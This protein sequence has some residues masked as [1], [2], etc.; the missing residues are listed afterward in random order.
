MKINPLIRLLAVL[1][2]CVAPHMLCA[3]DTVCAQV[4]IR[5]LQK[6]TMERQGFEATLQVANGL[7]ETALANFTVSLLFSDTNGNLISSGTDPNASGLTFWYRAQ[8]GSPVVVNATIAGGATQTFKWLIVP[9]AGAAQSSTGG[10]IY[11]VGANISYSV[12]GVTQTT[13]VAPDYVQVYPTPILDLE[14]FLPEQVIGQDPNTPNMFLP[15]VPFSLGVRIRNSGLGTAKALNISSGQPQIVR[16]DT[17]L[18]ISFQIMG[19]EVQGLPSIP[20][21]LVNFGDV[22]GG[23]V[24]VGRWIMEA[25][26]TGKFTGFTAGFDHTDALGG[27]ATSL[28]RSATTYR[29]LGEVIQSDSDAIPDFLGY[30]QGDPGHLF[31]FPSDSSDKIAVADVSASVSP[32]GNGGILSLGGMLPAGLIFARS[33]QSSIK[34]LVVTSVTRSD[35]STLQARNAWVS[36]AQDIDGSFRWHYYLNIF[37]SI[38]YPGSYSYTIQLGAPQEG[39]HSPV[40]Q[41]IPDHYLKVDGSP[42]AYS[43]LVR[44]SDQDGDAVSLGSGALPAGATFNPNYTG[45]GIASGP[46]L[47]TGLFSWTPTANDAGEYTVRFTASDGQVATARTMGLH[48]ISGTASLVDAWRDKNWPGVSDPGIIGNEA[49]PAGDGYPNLMKYALGADPTKAEG[50]LTTIG[51]VTVGGMTYL[52]LTYVVR[53]DDPTLT[54]AVQAGNSLMAGGIWTDLD[55]IACGISVDQSDVPDGFQ[56][57]TVRDSQPVSD[58]AASRRYLR[59]KV[60]EVHGP[61]GGYCR[62]PIAAHGSSVIGAPLLRDA[63]AAG[64]VTATGSNQITVSDAEWIQNQF[65]SSSQPYYMEVATGN[66]AGCFFPILANSA[67]TLILESPDL[68]N[69][70]LGTLAAD[71]NATSFGT[72]GSLVMTR[73]VAGDLVRVRQA[74]T[75]GTLLGASGSTGVL[76][77]VAFGTAVTNAETVSIPDNQAIGIYKQPLVSLINVSG[78]GWL[79]SSGTDCTNWAI[80]PGSA[81]ILHRFG[82]AAGRELVVVGNVQTAPVAL[83]IPGIPALCNPLALSG[84]EAQANEVYLAPVM[85]ET[86]AVA[87]AGLIGNGSGAF[88]F[89]PSQG[90]LDRGDELCSFATGATGVI[91]PDAD[92]DACFSGPTGQWEELGALG[93]TSLRIEPGRGYLLRLKAGNPGGYWRQTPNY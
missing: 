28:I 6:L 14:Y 83:K 54:F 57:V 76:N 31:L 25:S 13:Q 69:H 68:N 21:L 52:A 36:A 75:I 87:D 82:N 22:P 48:V 65:V 5:I 63:V 58:P 55:G 56:R 12:K 7:P 73:V 42:A 41:V 39:N 49:N 40:I 71:V 16:N 11:F 66:L 2:F 44:A 86:V 27:A 53:T 8:T 78:S 90:A 26:L 29:L 18:A 24:A 60:N 9:T 81:L 91:H 23:G 45:A 61:P 15:P 72:S 35:G 20:S 38:P 89:Q 62:V 47:A 50:T 84:T 88:V 46:G 19:S 80:Q 30:T 74:W 1:L 3:S 33:E 51:T 64:R 4:Q 79:D 93:T 59:L 34:G 32:G 37:D 92:R 43:Y 17:G 77:A 10:T 85:A 70:P 67:D